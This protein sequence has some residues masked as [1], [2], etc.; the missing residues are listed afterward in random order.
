[1]V[2]IYHVLIFPIR[3][4]D[5]EN[6]DKIKTIILLIGPS[7]SGKTW[8]TSKVNHLVKC[9]SHDRNELQDCLNSNRQV[10][11][12]ETPVAWSRNIKLLSQRA[13][14]IV[15]PIGS[16]LISIKSNLICRGGRVTKSLYA[17][18]NRLKRFG[19]PMMP[20]EA[21][22]KIK[23]LCLNLNHKHII[24]KATSPSGKVYIGKTIKTLEQRRYEHIYHANILNKQW[25][26]SRAIRK[27]GEENIKFETIGEV[28][29][30][31]KANSIETMYI[32]QYR[33][34][35]P[36]YG[37]NLTGGGDGRT[38][39]NEESENNRRKAISEAL[40]RPQTSSRLREITT[41]SWQNDIVRDNRT[42]NIKKTR[43]S[44]ESRAKTSAAARD[45]YDNGDGRETMSRVVKD[46]YSDPKV[47]KAQGQKARKAKAKAFTCHTLDGQYVDTFYNNMEAAEKL[48]IPQC[49]ISSALHGRLRQTRGY[50]FTYIPDP[51]DDKFNQQEK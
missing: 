28:W 20:Q 21:V 41:N 12:Y 27:Y 14:L 19:K 18:F 2:S 40:S 37:Y 36:E 38:W 35:E 39:L 43:S 17:R 22:E 8:V 7:G 33:C 15:L 10:C 42:R 4:I 45:W 24:Y 30:S 23:D 16:D 32:Q 48:G 34:N 6:N 47:G 11:L 25:A 49:G 1:M 13:N 26:F 3:Y 29:G 46:R 44:N 5:M 51:K 50:V 9:F 31:E